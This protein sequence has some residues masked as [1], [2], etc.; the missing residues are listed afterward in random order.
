MIVHRDRLS[1]PTM[2]IELGRRVLDL[3]DDDRDRAL[4]VARDLERLLREA[5][6][7]GEHCD[8]LERLA[9]LET[10]PA[11]RREAL[12]E[13][14]RLS[15]EHLE[16]HERSIKAQ[17]LRLTD[18]P[19]DLDALD[20]L[21]ASL[22]IQG[23]AKEL[24]DALEQRATNTDDVMGARRDRGEVARRLAV[25][26]RLP[27]EAITA[28]TRIRDD[29]GPDDESCDALADLL[30]EAGRHGELVEMLEVEVARSQTEERSAALAAMLGDV[31]R[32]GTGELDRAEAAYR[33]AI[34]KRVEDPRARRGLEAMLERLEPEGEGRPL[35]ARVVEL[36][37]RISKVADDYGTTIELLP[38]RLAS[39]A[40]DADK[41]GVLRE[42]A[43]LYRDRRDDALGAFD[44][45]WRA[46]LLDPNNQT[47]AEEVIEAAPL[48]GRWDVV[49]RELADV[50]DG[51][52]DPPV[53]VVRSLWWK[54]AEWQRD[55][56]QD[57]TAA[58][59]SYACALAADPENV[60][61][62]AALAEL[63]RRSK[64][65]PL[66]ET[67]LRLSRATAGDLGL[68]REAVEIAVEHVQDRTLSHPI[69]DEMLETA[70]KAWGASED[71][72]AGDATVLEVEGSAGWALDVKVQLCR[73]DDDDEAV[74]QV[75]LRGSKMP[76]D[77]QKRRELL[78][79]A[80]ELSQGDVAI[81]LFNELF[82]Q[83]PDDVLVAGRLEALF[84]AAG[85][86]ED[87]LGLR[88]RQIAVA[89]TDQAR[90]ALRLHVAALHI[91]AEDTDRAIA[92]LCE[93]L[94]ELPTHGGAVLRLGEL[95][96]TAERHKDLLELWESQAK[97]S[98]DAEETE[99]AAELWSR[100]AQL[101]EERLEDKRRAVQ[102][103]RRSVGLVEKEAAL[104]ALG[105]LLTELND[106]AGASQVLSRLTELA[107]DENITP[108]MLRLC[109]SLLGAGE[110]DEARRR[111]EEVLS[112][113]DAVPELVQRLRV[114]YEQVEAWTELAALLTKEAAS[115]PDRATRLARLREAAD[116]HLD[117]RGDPASAIPL[118]EEAADL[119]PE[120]LS[121]RL[122][123]C[124]AMREAGRFDEATQVL[125]DM[126]AEYGGRRPK[127]RALVHHE[128]AR[129]ALA[130]GDRAR[131]L[132]ELDIAVK[133]DPGH[134][135]ILHAI[136]TLALEEG[137]LARAQRMFRA[138]LLV[139]RSHRNATG[140][141]SGGAISRAEVL[142][143]L[144]DIAEREGETERSVEFVESA[145]EVALES[146]E[147]SQR[148]TGSLRRREKFELL[149]RALEAR[150]GDG[151]DSA[152]TLVELADVYEDHLD[153][154]SDA[155]E[156]RLK[157]LALNPGSAESH[158]RTLALCRKQEKVGR[159]LETLSAAVAVA[160][161]DEDDTAKADT[162]VELLLMKGKLL[163]E[164]K[165]EEASAADVYRQAESLLEER[166]DASRRWSRL[167][168]VW[169][170]L[171]AV[172][173]RE[174]DVDAQ[175]EVLE[176][177]AD[178]VEAEAD[179]PASEKAKPLYRLAALRFGREDTHE[180]ACGLL[181][182]AMDLD[183]DD[184]RKE[185]RL[186]AAVEQAPKE[187]RLL[188]LFEDFCRRTE[189]TRALV[190]ALLLLAE[191]EAESSPAWREAADIA[192]E[193]ED[194]ALHESIL[195]RFLERSSEGDDGPGGD[196]VWALCRLAELCLAKDEVQEAASLK[197]K[198]GRVAPPDEERA[199]LL[200]VAR[201]A[202]GPLEDLARAAGL[203]EELCEREP[204]D[205][206]L[207]EPLMEVHRRMGETEKLST[208]IEATV[209]LIDD[210]KERGN[211]R[212]ERVRIVVEKDAEQAILELYEILEEDAA[213]EEA[214]TILFGLLEKA[215][216]QEDLIELLNRQ[217]DAAKDHEDRDTIVAV[218]MRLGAL[219]EQRDQSD[220]ALDIYHAALDWDAESRETLRAVV[221]LN[222]ARDDSVDLGD[223]LMRLL[224]VEE[225]EAA[226]KLALQLCELKR[227]A[228]DE[229]AAEEALV[230]GYRAYPASVQLRDD[231]IK[232]FNEQEAWDRLAEVYVLDASTREVPSERVE[233]LFQAAE[234]LRERAQDPAG[235]VDILEGALK[236]SPRDRDVLHALCDAAVEL[237]QPER[238]AAKLTAAIEADEAED[239]WLYRSRAAMHDAMGAAEAALEDLERA[240]NTSEGNYAREYAEH[241]E[242]A[243]ERAAEMSDAARE[244]ELRLRLAQVLHSGGDVDRAR[245]TLGDIVRK[246]PRDRFALRALAS[247]EESVERW[248]AVSA[249]YRRLVSIE[250]GEAL[251]DAAL[252]LGDACE[253]AARPGDARGGLERAL[254][255]NPSNTE[256]RDCLRRVYVAT[257]AN[258]E[259]AELVLDDAKSAADVQGR[260]EHLLEAG[261]L[262]L[263]SDEDA[264]FAVEVL[265]EAVGL[266]PEEQDCLLLLSEA[267]AGAGRRGEAVNI[268]QDAVA[269]YKGRRSPRLGRVYE[270]MARLEL[271][272]GKIA[273]ALA[274]LTKAFE[275]DPSN[276][277]LAL[278]LGTFAID[279]DE[280][281][282]ATRA[283]RAVT[284]MK[285]STDGS[286]L[287]PSSADRALAYYHLGQ[288]ANLQGDRRKARLMLEKSVSEDPH[289]EVARNLLEELR[290]G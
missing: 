73:E 146:P 45:T 206:E 143:E 66:I 112:T 160:M 183:E 87:L 164:E 282:T 135:A 130:A 271:R 254:R 289:L 288:L 132:G 159:Y 179:V 211:L 242:R 15:S 110:P 88:A 181:E 137:Q 232:R 100:A 61:L 237:G 222:I 47:V 114:L 223:S 138:L 252:R 176:K 18:D 31:H 263:R 220:D 163:E 240:H 234:L 235:A 265:E 58:E 118:L 1:D 140:R 253:R 153:R 238:G 4:D 236:D 174:G 184:D 36:L 68:L 52:E 170:A 29:F 255:V 147:E 290:A 210:V 208:L 273:E 46:F 156:A 219:L 115:A 182:R 75:F 78:M 117:R 213:H 173:E 257:G 63:Q 246:D 3:C 41:V 6:R 169:Q 168:R 32:E 127:D 244:R 40:D 98:E 119:S 230:L 20:G 197:E 142:L 141:R 79:S 70:V 48:A 35:Y 81:E 267:Y 262:L 120:D 284:M 129:L 258:R 149:A 14:A 121:I 250:E 89:K 248:D 126:I 276:H 145:F 69:V 30:L 225:G 185:E 17:R 165:S 99:A 74:R 249:T 245:M 224:G 72:T 9:D 93:T 167:E 144:S 154:P 97:H 259:L 260:Y 187:Q 272:D 283:F 227:A 133:I 269:S 122:A 136:A 277:R 233:R 151:P 111:L 226:E 108:R 209:P 285:T 23:R 24:V 53:E 54:L 256:V 67:L 50:L 171:E 247:L 128:L 152:P 214:G 243:A 86:R 90:A 131:A 166:V 264:G 56:L 162:A 105:R 8:V 43:T 195:R 158:E 207:W 123:V 84:R 199:L 157:A 218:S 62:L 212:L 65:R 12:S 188:R 21:V 76:F 274:L 51:S 101:A 28:W 203:Y 85:R 196:A 194:A 270:T 228:G 91:E 139:L 279:L 37:T 148:L 80:A 124:E 161:A 64:G 186:R 59:A 125:K 241:L 217:L 116:L 10:E 11:A 33:S 113:R 192:Q 49:A 103:Y 71:V 200:A 261:R 189:R 286:G 13:V 92:V 102:D 55:A 26:L 104:D 155:L 177:L 239:P 231:L 198:A 44:C 172:Y 82:E 109:D 106:H 107:S 180:D 193:L 134:P 16:D 60:D 42:T 201:L 7:T 5:G 19:K 281:E 27:A 215:G 287:G 39:A 268:L 83:D 204:A 216:R 38:S 22:R 25:D 150:L 190:D 34:E 178:G 205:R 2:A 77:A 94:G 95:Y 202:A 278:E 266:Q 57:P 251:V 229:S 96:Q 175:A 280:R 221:R 191:E 275:N